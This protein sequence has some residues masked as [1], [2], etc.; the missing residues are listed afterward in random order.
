MLT[1]SQVRNDELQARM[2]KYMF[3]LERV[4]K[5]LEDKER[6]REEMVDNLKKVSEG[7]CKLQSKNISMGAE[8]CQ[9]R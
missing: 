3:E 9:H 7:S 1:E 2:K 8:L 4:G 6:E 5:A